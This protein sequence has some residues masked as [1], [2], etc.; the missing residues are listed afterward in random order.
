MPL[1]SHQTTQKRGNKKDTVELIIP[2]NFKTT[3]I[4]LTKLII[5]QVRIFIIEFGKMGLQKLLLKF[6][7]DWS[8]KLSLILVLSL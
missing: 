3:L 2:G 4:L 7:L 8:E 5:V 1:L 6:C